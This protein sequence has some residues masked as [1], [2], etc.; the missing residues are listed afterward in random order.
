MNLPHTGSPT[1]ND[2]AL[3]DS[4]AARLA[5][6]GGAV[7]LSEEE[8]S[9]VARALTLLAED[10]SQ[11]AHLRA[12]LDSYGHDA[13]TVAAELASAQGHLN[14]ALAGPSPAQGFDFERAQH[15][16]AGLI[17]ALEAAR[18]LEQVLARVLA[19]VGA[20]VRVAS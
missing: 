15:E 18:S 1:P 8:R 7:T 17:R 20:V 2:A 11:I 9:L 3:F 6:P 10:Q 12:L 19:F 5:H 14:D 13:R 16:R 4:L